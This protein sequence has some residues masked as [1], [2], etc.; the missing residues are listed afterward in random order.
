[1]AQFLLPITFVLGF[2]AV[3]LMAQSVATLLFTN[4]DRSRRVNRRMSLLESGMDRRDVLELL[5]RRPAAPGFKNAH[6][7]KAYDFAITFLGQAGITI[8]PVH[9]LIGV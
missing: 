4:R 6:L 9:I 2:V 7:L 3:A 8:S 5:V 1:M